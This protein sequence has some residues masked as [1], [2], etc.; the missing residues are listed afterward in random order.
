MNKKIRM[1]AM[2]LAHVGLLLSLLYLVFFLVCSV[3]VNR[4]KDVR[5][6]IDQKDLYLEQAM[7]E[8]DF[9]FY[10][11]GKA[12]SDSNDPARENLLVAADLIIPVLCM[13]SGILLQVAAVHPRRRHGAVPQ[14]KPV[15]STSFRR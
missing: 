15:Q 1:I 2:I 9:S 10:T 7:N 3:R 8:R 14:Q 11:V 6:E 13:T 4:A 5:A 12:L